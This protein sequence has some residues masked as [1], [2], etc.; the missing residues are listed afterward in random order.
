MAETK[1]H[2]LPMELWRHPEPTVTQ[3]WAFKERIEKRYNT[4]FNSYIELYQWSI[5]NVAEFWKETWEFTGQPYGSTPLG[6]V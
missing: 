3:I 4:K 1:P 6:K 2:E 5:D